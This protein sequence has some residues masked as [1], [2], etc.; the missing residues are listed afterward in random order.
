MFGSR[1]EWSRRKSLAAVTIAAVLVTGAMAGC[2][3]S[4]AATTDSATKGSIN[5]W[6]WTPEIGVGKQ[7]IAAFNKKYPNIKVTYKQV[8]TASYDAA[9]RPALASSVGP[10]VFNMAPGGGIGS[11]TAYQGSAMDLTPVVKKALGSDWKSKVAAIG[12]AGLT[13]ADGKLAALAVGSTFA[14]PVW[15]NPELFSKYGLKP[16]K[17]LADWVQVC[18]SFASH[19]VTCF[20]QGAGD[21]GFNMDLLH[22]IA[23]SIEPGVWSKAVAGKA[24]WTDPSLVK[25]MTTFKTMFGNGII[26]KGALGVQQYPDVNNDFLAGKTAMVMMGTWYMQY[27]TVAGATSA[28]S[29]AGVAEAKPFP[30]VS[31][32]F[33]DIT[34]A[35]NPAPLFGDADYGLAVNTKSKSPKA[36]ATFVTWLATNTDA[37]QVVA[38]SLNDIS[39]LTDVAPKWS[40]IK[41]VDGSQ[42]QPTLQTL[43]GSASKIT[44]PR[45]GD[46]STA[47]GQAIGIATASVA[48][49]KATPEQALATLQSVAK[50]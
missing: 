28:V 20:E 47:V 18:S 46:L 22:A 12:P 43:I 11:I 41:L 24:K 39:A 19:N 14:G 5:W 45:L 4:G 38:N 35:G 29:A 8:A 33:P 25:A 21:S 34:G 10:D 13:T 16:P 15:V 9:I 49:G 1:P 37:Q 23:D 7:Y 50:G 17:T 31:I 40:D 27:S 48:G 2:S 3:S 32:P 6:G 44:E 36:A 26:Q 30:I 42:Q